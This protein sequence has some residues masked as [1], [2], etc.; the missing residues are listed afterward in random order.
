M[1]P[2]GASGRCA[3]LLA[4]FLTISALPPVFAAAAYDPLPTSLNAAVPLLEPAVAVEDPGENLSLLEQR[5]KDAPESENAWRDLGW[6]YMRH[7]FPDQARRT[8]ENWRRL[9]PV[10]PEVH[11]LLGQL[12]L[13]ENR[14]PDAIDSFRRSLELYPDQDDIRFN[15]ARTLRWAGYLGESIER[16]REMLEKNPGDTAI[17]LELARALSSNWEYAAALTLW[18]FLLAK[19]P[20]DRELQMG[21]AQALL[22]TGSPRLA[23]ITAR[24]MLEDEPANKTALTILTDE[25]EY[26]QRFA[27]A[28]DW[29]E[30]LIAATESKSNRQY[31]RNRLLK[32]MRNAR[33]RDPATSPLVKQLELAREI[34]AAEPRNIDARLSLAELKLQKGLLDKAKTLLVTVLRE[35]NPHHYRTHIILFEIALAQRAF[36][37]AKSHLEQMRRFH[38]RDPYLLWYE[39]RL[40]ETMGDYAAAED[41]LDRLA[42][43]GERGATAVLLYH[44]LTPSRFGPALSVERFREHLRALMAAEYQF[45]TPEEIHE[46]WKRQ[47]CRAGR[48]PDGRLRRVVAVTFDDALESAMRFGTEI[49]REYGI[50]FGQYIPVGFVERGD[51]YIATWEQLARYGKYGVWEYGNHL[52]YAHDPLDIDMHGNRGLPAANRKWLAHERR[53]ETESEYAMRLRREYEESREK[54]TRHLGH[55]CRVVAYPYGDIGQE[56]YSNMP[57]AIPLNLQ[58]AAR[59][60]DIGFIQ[61]PFSHAVCGADPLLYGRHE[62]SIHWSGEQVAQYLLDR[63]P[64]ILAERT[65]L[66]FA[67]W[68]GNPAAARQALHKL[69]TAGYPAEKIAK[70]TAGMRTNLVSVFPMPGTF[71]QL[72]GE[73]IARRNRGVRSEISG[74][75]D[76]FKARHFRATVQGE[77]DLGEGI[78]L[79][80]SVGAGRLAQ[81]KKDAGEPANTIALTETISELAVTFIDAQRRAW[82]AGAGWRGWSGDDRRNRLEGRAEVHG[83][84]IPDLSI[85]LGVASD[86]P[87]Q[88]RALARGMHRTRLFG[89][90]HWQMTSDWALIFD[91]SWER[92]SD[93]NILLQ[94]N[95]HPVLAPVAWHGAYVGALLTHRRSEKDSPD[96][97]TPPRADGSYV[98]A[99][100]RGRLGAGQYNIT[101]QA[102]AA[103]EKSFDAAD[104]LNNREDTGTEPVGNNAWKEAYAANAVWNRTLSKHWSGGFQ[105]SWRYSSSYREIRWLLHGRYRF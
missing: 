37:E 21:E 79:A 8:W 36:T 65:R 71:R 100:H 51:P 87:D 74:F 104:A 20:D 80:T 6:A 86:T 105:S 60:H 27:E 3:G 1:I 22:H 56:G 42:A 97:W 33:E 11:A 72:T 32:I 95:M 4:V 28:A 2:R 85:R 57:N 58:H 66:D 19:N 52:Y 77:I 90:G 9:N 70:M 83:R 39:A 98:T 53:R 67:Q 14:L 31:L 54:I 10:N 59:N 13:A 24:R 35:F 96:I 40:R 23:V 25:A 49:G 99:G 5:V 61:T 68:R 38:P 45:V 89:E 17:Q 50:R 16:L 84:L 94:G 48:W 92:L 81:G 102:G 43:A 76:N 46:D 18:S 82:T 75:G 88:A 93:N 15:L 55:P 44:A 78:H 73:D 34:A 12:A 64:V 101:L 103:R 91:A 62:M 29:L 7:N 69:Q 41:S 47:G 30:K 26:N 63:H